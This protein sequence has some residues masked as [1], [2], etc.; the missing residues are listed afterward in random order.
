MPDPATDAEMSGTEPTASAVGLTDLARELQVPTWKL[1]DKLE[2]L[3]FFARDEHV[4]IKDHVA[5]RVRDAYG[6]PPGEPRKASEDDTTRST[7]STHSARQERTEHTA[8]AGL[9][10]GRVRFFEQSRGYGFIAGDDGVDYFFHVTK[11][12]SATAVVT[13]HRVT[14]E[15]GTSTRGP[16]A[17]HVAVVD[18]SGRPTGQQRQRFR[19]PDRFIMTKNSTVHGFDIVQVV[20]PTCWYEAFDPN[21]AKEGLQTYAAS[22]GANAIVN[23]SLE[24]YSKSPEPLLLRLI[25]IAPN[26]Y[27]TMHR[28]SGAAVII[29]RSVRR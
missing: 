3:G 1:L 16:R 26:Y 8:R 24:K 4:K 6:I 2:E 19:E 13:G 29:N 9:L 23:L 17:S 28:F 15:P 18:D 14:F 11:V 22:L 7:E 20:A 5:R 12:I 10:Y 21:E 27:R 25:G